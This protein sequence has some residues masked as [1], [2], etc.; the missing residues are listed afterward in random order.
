MKEFFNNETAVA[1]LALYLH[2]HGK[3]AVHP[4]AHL[5]YRIQRISQAMHRSNLRAYLEYADDEKEQKET[6]RLRRKLRRLLDK[7]APEAQ[8][9]NTNRDPRG[10]PF[11]I[12]L[13]GPPLVV[14][15]YAVGDV[16]V[17]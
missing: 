11:G 9:T 2:A 16:D 8:V 1:E 5:A 3:I 17:V 7:E 12:M 6:E 15:A 14:L 4:A 13:G 10:R